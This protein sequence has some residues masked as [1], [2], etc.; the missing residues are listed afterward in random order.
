MAV[1]VVMNYLPHIGT[2]GEIGP[3]DGYIK[4]KKTS[5]RGT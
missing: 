4:E 3:N 1:M 2:K 5:L